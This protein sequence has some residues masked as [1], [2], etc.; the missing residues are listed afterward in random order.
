MRSWWILWCHRGSL[1]NSSMNFSIK[2][3]RSSRWQFTVGPSMSIKLY[4]IR[5]WKNKYEK[6]RP[7]HRLRTS[8]KRY[9]SARR[10]S[11]SWS[12]P[13][14]K[15]YSR[16]WRRRNYTCSESS[17]IQKWSGRNRSAWTK[18]SGRVRTIISCCK[19]SRRKLRS[20]KWTW[21]PKKL[22]SPKSQVLF[23]RMYQ[24]PRKMACLTSESA[25]LQCPP[26][27]QK[28]PQHLQKSQHLRHHQSIS[29]NRSLW[30]TKT[31]L[32]RLP[33]KP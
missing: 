29:R 3:I 1:T 5:L 23:D 14:I 17:T 32:K 11:R 12:I 27:S 6:H 31:V 13:S 33:I 24:S 10:G 16:R 2:L 7:I 21:Y 8:R 25:L 15:L 18:W 20:R 28:R 4:S 22:D 9:W 19:L 26:N 30:V